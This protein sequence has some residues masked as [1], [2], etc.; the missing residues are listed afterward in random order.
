M[1]ALIR[2]T[3][4][5]PLFLVLLTSFSVAIAF[6]KEK[7]MAKTYGEKMQGG[8]GNSAGAEQHRGRA[9]APQSSVGGVGRRGSSAISRLRS[10]FDRLFDDFLGGLGGLP[11]W[12]ETRDSR[13][14]LDVE[15]QDDKLVVRAEA[16]GFEPDDFDI[17]VR[18]DQLV[19]CACQSEEKQQEGSRQWQQQELYRSITLPQGIDPEHVDAQYRNGVL[20]VTLPKTEQGKSR[21]IDVKS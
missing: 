2:R 15:D 6:A 4:C 12:P 16:P 18:D 17:Q 10:E 7:V 20:T 8:K 14:G 3:F 1:S 13:W 5:D 11:A 21:R 19:L 9:M